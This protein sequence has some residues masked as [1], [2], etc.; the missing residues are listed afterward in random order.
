LNRRKTETPGLSERGQLGIA[1]KVIY[2]G[3][4]IHSTEAERTKG[5]REYGA[6]EGQFHK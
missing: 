1:Q 3:K 5:G 2:E 4:A 6:G